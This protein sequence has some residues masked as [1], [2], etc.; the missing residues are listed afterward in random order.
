MPEHI[1]RT[2]AR[3]LLHLFT[4]VLDREHFFELPFTTTE[5][6]VAMKWEQEAI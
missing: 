1:T 5:W 4:Y 6:I 2:D 3:R